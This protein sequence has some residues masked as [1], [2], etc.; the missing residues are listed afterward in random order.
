MVFA[1]I[2]DAF[3]RTENVAP[4]KCSKALKMILEFYDGVF[5]PMWNSSIT[6]LDK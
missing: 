6:L 1:T 3:P 5:M 2:L 4:Q